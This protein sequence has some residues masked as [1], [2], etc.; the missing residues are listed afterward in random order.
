MSTIIY[1]TRQAQNVIQGIIHEQWKLEQKP[2]SKVA[3]GQKVE[4]RTYVGLSPSW[5]GMVMVRE[6]RIGERVNWER[7]WAEHEFVMEGVMALQV[8]LL[9]PI[10]WMQIGI[11]TR[12]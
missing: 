6:G 1:A 9:I 8:T 5:R 2:R 4:I 11:L 7:N 3:Q 12:F 10:R